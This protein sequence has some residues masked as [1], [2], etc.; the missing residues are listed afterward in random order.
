VGPGPPSGTRLAD[1]QSPDIAGRT[2]P[3]ASARAPV[4]GLSRGGRQR[5]LAN[6]L[7]QIRRAAGLAVPRV[8]TTAT[9][10]YGWVRT[11]PFAGPLRATILPRMGEAPVHRSQTP[12]ASEITIRL[13]GKV[14]TGNRSLPP[15]TRIAPR[16]QHL[17]ELIPSATFFP[18]LGTGD[19][20]ASARRGRDKGVPAW[21]GH[22]GRKAPGRT[23]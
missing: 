11:E 10:T 14:C 3:R 9:R 19:V 5:T 16:Y 22:L 13:E 1:D 6:G 4:D 2:H 18:C 7:S 17:R 15:P 23:S 8:T 20:L 12:K 21:R